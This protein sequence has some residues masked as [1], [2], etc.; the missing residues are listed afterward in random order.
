MLDDGAEVSAPGLP[1]AA[2]PPVAGMRLILCGVGAGARAY[3]C[4]GNALPFPAAAWMWF[5]G[6]LQMEG[7]HPT[8]GEMAPLVPSPLARCHL[9][10]QTPRFPSLCHLLSLC[11]CTSQALCEFGW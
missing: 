7:A 4:M 8:E 1:L 9:C 6:Q 5:L 11:P 2:L 10:L 3:F